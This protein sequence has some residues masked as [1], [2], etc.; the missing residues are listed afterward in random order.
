[1]MWRNT[2]IMYVRTVSNCNGTFILSMVYAVIDGG[3]DSKYIVYNKWNDSFELVDYWGKKQGYRVNKIYRLRKETDGFVE[4][5]NEQLLELNKYCEE[6]KRSPN[7]KFIKN[8]L[9]LR[10]A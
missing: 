10:H 7:S 2:D 9:N 5:E 8:I 3:R 6:N 1:M 4:Y